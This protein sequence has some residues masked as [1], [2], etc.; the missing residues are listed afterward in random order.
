MSD[1][2]LYIAAVILLPLFPAFIIFKLIPGSTADAQG[3]F[4]GLKLKLG[5]AFAGYFIVVLVAFAEVKFILAKSRVQMWE[6]QG[7]VSLADGGTPDTSIAAALVHVEPPNARIRDAYGK[8]RFPLAIAVEHSTE[9]SPLLSIS[10]P[11]YRSVTLELD[12]DGK[13]V[14]AYVDDAQKTVHIDKKNSV[15]DVGHVVLARESRP[16]GGPH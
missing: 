11:G 10:C 5:G 6:I 12:P 4:Q 15:I 9:G 16:S 14:S 8:L 3:P 13:H 1:D 2:F 7:T